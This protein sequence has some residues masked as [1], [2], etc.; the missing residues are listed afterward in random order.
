MSRQLGRKL[1]RFTTLVAIVGSIALALVLLLA[2]TSLQGCGPSLRAAS[3]MK[4]KRS[5]ETPKDASVIIDEQYVGP[6]AYVAARGVR[7]P[8]GEHRLSV[9]KEGYFPYDTIIEVDGREQL[10]TIDVELTPIPD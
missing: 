5:A 6:L 10:I 4:L 3:T 9:E 2:A 8:E 7:L 1:S